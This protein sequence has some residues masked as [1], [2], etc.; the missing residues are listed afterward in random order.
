MI[1]VLA[2]PIAGI[3]MPLILVPTVVVLK[4]RQ[5]RREWEHRERMKA[6]EFGVPMV[7]SHPWA[8]ATAAIAIG[9]GAPASAF[10]FCWLAV[11]TSQVSDGI[12]V[13]AGFVGVAGVISGARLATR[14]FT[15]SGSAPASSEVPPLHARDG[16]PAFDP[17]TFD[18]V[19]QRG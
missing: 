10:L 3:L 7:V 17:D 14:L 12:F 16:K 15:G 5:R 18:V 2:I 19:G 8:A 4:G 6:L 9:L 11:K 13:A 1:D